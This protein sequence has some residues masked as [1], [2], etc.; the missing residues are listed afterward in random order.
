MSHPLGSVEV[1]SS[2]IVFFVLLAGLSS[3]VVGYLLGVSLGRA[4]ASAQLAV[5]RERADAATAR[6]S[7][8]NEERNL[9]ADQ[10]SDSRLNVAHERHGIEAMVKP[11]ADNLARLENA[12]AQTEALR[13]E[14]LGGLS[15]QLRDLAQSNARVSAEAASLKNALRSSNT[16]GRWGEVQLRRVV[17][18]AGMLHH[19]DFEEQVVSHDGSSGKADLVVRLPGNVNIPVDAK[20][21]Y[22]AYDKAC[23]AQDAESSRA[24]LKAHARDVRTHIDELAKREYWDLYGPTPGFCVMFVPGDALLEAALS[25]D[26]ALWDH[27]SRSKILFATPTS[28]IALLRMA[29]LGWARESQESDAVEIVA[30]GRELHKRLMKALVEVDKVGRGLKGAIGAYNQLIGSVDARLMPQAKRLG[31]LSGVVEADIRSLAPIDEPPR[32]ANSLLKAE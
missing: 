17:E 14:N 4:R 15:E 6:L 24:H 27:A 8:V 2:Q 28:L 10:L 9:L 11:V 22:S 12:L 13:R 29:A 16:R 32:T 23:E 3:L 1:M 19:V 18:I 31:D 5:M 7:E 26:P 21:P 25:A 30:A 20:V